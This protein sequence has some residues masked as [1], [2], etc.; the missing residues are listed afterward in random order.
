[1]VST[2]GL[3][4]L[5]QAA[6]HALITLHAA[7]CCHAMTDFNSTHS[8]ESSLPA[9]D[10]P[11]AAS[12]PAGFGAWV[13]E[14][15]AQLVACWRDPSASEA[16][17]GLFR[18]RQ[19]HAVL[20]AMVTSGLGNLFTVVVMSALFWSRADHGAL[21]AWMAAV[22]VSA[23]FN[24]WLGWRRRGMTVVPAASRRT[25]VLFSADIALAALAFASMP[26][27]LFGTVG[28]DGRTLVMSILV[29][30]LLIGSWMMAYLP[31]AAIAWALTL[32]AGT[33]ITLLAND[34]PFFNYTA[35]LMA[36]LGLVAVVTV[37]ITSRIFMGSLKSEA[38]IE[39][40]KQ[41][42]GLLLN[43]FEEH[44]SD[45]LWETDG[46][47]RLRHVA[48]RLAQSLGVAPEDLQG[49]SLV[50][51]ISS[52]SD[53]LRRADQARFKVLS[54]HLNADVPFRDVVVPALV[55]GELQWW[56]LTGKPLRDEHGQ[57]VGWRG[58][59]SDISPQW[60]HE[61][62]LVRL[63]NEDALTGLANRYKFK[64][65][66]DDFFRAGEGP[67]SAPLPC[68]LFLFDLDNFKTLN[69][70]LGHAVGDQLLVEVARR[71]SLEMRRDELL[72][73]L[74]GD[75]FVVLVPGQLQADDAAAF[76][77]RMQAAL[78]QPWTVQGRRIVIHASIGVGFAPQDASS[79]DQLLRVV[80]LALYAA[81]AAGRH[82][83]RFFEPA[84]AR[85]AS[86]KLNVLSDM[87]QGL[88]R[89]EFFLHYQ[90]QIDI[91]SGAP[92]GF[93]ALVRWQHPL[94]G[95]IPP[96]EFI[97]IAEESGQIE[98][99]G[100]WVLRRACLDATEWP[101]HL[102]VAVNLSALQFQSPDLLKMIQR[103]LTHSGLSATRLELELTESALFQ[104]DA[105]AVQT[106]QAL[107]S[108]GIRIALDDFGTGYSSMSYLRK[109]A[110]DKLKIDRSF[111]AALDSD[112]VDASALAIVRAIIQ[113]AQALHMETTAEGVETR[114]GLDTL[115][116]IGCAQ[117]QGFWVA[118]PM[119]IE[120][121]RAF[122]ASSTPKHIEN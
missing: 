48:T 97:P 91:N 53:E 79:A 7:S 68:T 95:L 21:I 32:C 78:N 66:L 45:W 58:V 73:R 98:A 41:V 86:Y 114:A 38:Q 75:E 99:L 64:Q 51:V 60:R 111:I 30:F 67:S 47:G 62:E 106:L 107:R 42:V 13:G 39:Q 9:I 109:F 36:F 17:E 83:L 117:A 80:D 12:V 52:M 92:L 103:A 82:T 81:K 74:G 112:V 104:D 56:S 105:R 121:T 108:V 55:H 110:L 115:K 122:I 4:I 76:G 46:R 40:Q 11:A 63:A 113:L 19:Y 96:V 24:A 18:G 70:S 50:G 87:A 25:I 34:I 59:G 2:A 71:L 116:R 43:D 54:N 93:E 77:Q 100:E 8:S 72:A 118:R 35:I 5:A 65:S 90:P 1:V 22:G 29:A 49:R 85:Q 94:R 3:A 28:S 89:D 61:Q 57:V 31:L 27:Y 16:Q 14:A 6:R 33:V 37:L 119:G 88:Q 10:A 44:A 69:D 84:M 102:R 23:L 20:M 26:W 15:V 101:A 120:Q